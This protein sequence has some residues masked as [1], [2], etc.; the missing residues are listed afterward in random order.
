MKVSEIRKLTDDKIHQEMD[1]LC[2]ERLNLRVRIA[3][4]SQGENTNRL[5]TI[6]K[7]IARCLTILRERKDQS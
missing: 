3:N 7:T 6:K 4:A 1:K 5:T 2:K